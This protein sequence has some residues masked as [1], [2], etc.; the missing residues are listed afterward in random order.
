VRRE[1]AR[2]FNRS[3]VDTAG[4]VHGRWLTDLA[5]GPILSHDS[6]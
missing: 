1:A 3:V 4:P 2:R 5:G 6:F